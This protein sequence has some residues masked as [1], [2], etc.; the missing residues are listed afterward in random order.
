MKMSASALGFQPDPKALLAQFV[1]GTEKLT[2]AARLSGKVRSAFPNG[3]PLAEGETPPEK[4]ESLKESAGSINVV[5]VA[6][7]DMLADMFW[8]RQ[9]ELFG[10][11]IGYSKI[12]ANGDMVTN[13]ID[14]LLG[15]SDLISIRARETSIRPFTRVEDLRTRA[16]KDLL[17]QEEEIEAQIASTERELSQLQAARGENADAFVLTPDQQK[18]VDNLETK[19]LEARREKRRLRLALNKDIES[20]A[21]RLKLVNLGMMPAAVTLLAVGVSVVRQSRRSRS[22]V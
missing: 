21:T 9:E 4:D 6:D 1:P 10:Q 13:A 5:L 7:V 20:L 19:L 2:L 22:R 18:A 3:R 8:S 14:N 17:K 12:A 15:S 11:I 16:A